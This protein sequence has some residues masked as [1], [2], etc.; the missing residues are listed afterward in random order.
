VAAEGGRDYEMR[1][2]G[3]DGFFTKIQSWSL[4][5]NVW[6]DVP[7]HDMVSWFMGRVPILMPVHFYT[8]GG[9]GMA[10][11]DTKTTDNFT[12]ASKDFY[13]FAWQVGAG[14]SYELTDQ[15]TISMGYR[16]FDPG[17]FKLKL[18]ISPDSDPFG[19]FKMDLSAH[20]FTTALR[21]DFYT[22]GLPTWR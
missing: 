2:K 7:M 5:Q 19:T 16:Y 10:A 21:V 13:N 11:L 22:L 9:V 3:G 4:M 15:V 1:T 12:K 14:L 17:S 18:R 6:V 20:E 8:G